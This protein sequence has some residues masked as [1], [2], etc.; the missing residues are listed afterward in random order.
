MD[1]FC[2]QVSVVLTMILV[3]SRKGRL[4][5]ENNIVTADF[6]AIAV[7]VLVCLYNLVPSRKQVN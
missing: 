2:P 7:L 3:V 6:E 5:N 1:C 4:I